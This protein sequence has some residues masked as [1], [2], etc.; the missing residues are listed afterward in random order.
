MSKTTGTKGGLQIGIISTIA[1][2]VIHAAYREVA[3]APSGGDWYWDATVEWDALDGVAFDG[4]V[5]F[6]REFD[7]WESPVFAS[8]T[9]RDVVLA[10]Q[11]S[12]T[13][14]NDFHHVFFEGTETL[15]TENGVTVVELITGS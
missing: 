4:P 9:H 1:P 5:R 13:D 15:R 2:D 10:M 11:A 3:P 6:V 7:S 14:L 8:A 12:I